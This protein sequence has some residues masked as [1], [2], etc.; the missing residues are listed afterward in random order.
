MKIG[1]RMPSPK[2]SLKARTTGRLKR[3]AKGAVNPVY[4]KKGMGFVNNPRKAVYNKF[5]KKLTFSPV[6]LIMMPIYL[7]WNL[8][9]LMMQ[10]T[11]ELMLLPFRMMHYMLKPSTEEATEDEQP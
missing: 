8:V 3:A 1:M 7:G 2:R 11:I 5:Y 10:I 9:V 6:G 4:G